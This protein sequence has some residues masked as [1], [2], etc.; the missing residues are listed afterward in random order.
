MG[1]TII[2]RRSGPDFLTLGRVT[3]VQTRVDAD[4]SPGPSPEQRDRVGEAA[5]RLVELRDGWPNPPGLDPADLGK[6]T[7]T[8]LDSQ[9]PTWLAIAHPDLNAPVV[10]ACGWPS[11]LAGTEVPERLFR[12][13]RERVAE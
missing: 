3:I 4:L 1:A 6:R 13:H 10:A 2:E 5:R 9:R 12:L 11:G 7:L 8:N